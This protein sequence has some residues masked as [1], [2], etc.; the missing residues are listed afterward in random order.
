MPKRDTG[1]LGATAPAVRLSD[2]PIGSQQSR[3]AARA[4]LEARREA[5]G[6]G[7]LFR[8]TRANRSRDPNRKC[9]CSRPDTGMFAVCRCFM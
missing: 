3:A 8:V 4:L 9:T 5:Q 6:E 7:I 1:R 2:Y